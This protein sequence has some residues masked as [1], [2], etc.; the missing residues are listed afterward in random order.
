[1]T[2]KINMNDLPD[3]MKSFV[4]NSNGRKTRSLSIDKVRG[5][6]LDVLYPIRSLNRSERDRVLRH[7]LKMNKV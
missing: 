7:A 6:A 3:E 4:T 5:Q 1:M 2:T